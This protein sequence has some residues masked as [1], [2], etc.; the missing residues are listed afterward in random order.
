MNRRG[1][2]WVCFFYPDSSLLGLIF[3]VIILFFLGVDSP[4]YGGIY[5]YIDENGDYHFTNCPK[6]LRF[7][8]YIREKGDSAP[9]RINSDQYDPMIAEFSEKYGIDSALVKAVIQ[10]E[11]GFDSY[12]ISRKGAKGLMQLMPQTAEQWQVI[13]LFNPRENIEG[14]VR[15]LKHLLDTFENNLSLS[16][17]AYN[18][19]K[20]AVIQH[21]SIPPYHETRNFVRKVLRFYESYKH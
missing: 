17:A 5:R 6:D 13:D 1:K 15:H 11:S 16:L 19:G 10:A 3:F 9:A 21:R 2:T 7:Q 12:A 18:A 20:D 14:G 4:C 8:L